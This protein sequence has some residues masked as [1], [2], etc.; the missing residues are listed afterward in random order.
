MLHK[1]PLQSQSLQS[2]SWT[3]IALAVAV[4]VLLGGAVPARAQWQLQASGTG[5][6]SPTMMG[7]PGSRWTTGIGTR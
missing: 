3:R 2:K 4:A 1:K 6:T 5:A 7:K